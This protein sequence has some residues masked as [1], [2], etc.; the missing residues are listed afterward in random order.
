MAKKEDELPMAHDLITARLRELP[1]GGRYRVLVDRLW[2][3]GVRRDAEL[4]E[5]WLKDVAPSAGLRQ[6]YGHDVERHGRFAARY[7][8]ELDAA[9]GDPPLARLAEL[10]AMRPVALLTATHRL[11]D[12]HVPI[13]AQFV[14]ERLSSPG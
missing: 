8:E 1:R 11:E 12:S 9:R 7:R 13:L 4:W 14:R 2:P 6:W 10:A 3:R 5:E